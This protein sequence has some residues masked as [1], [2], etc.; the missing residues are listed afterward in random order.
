[1]LLQG[2]NRA[3]AEAIPARKRDLFRDMDAI[4]WVIVG[5]G[6]DEDQDWLEA[7]RRETWMERRAQKTPPS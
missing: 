7:I 4:E 5:H 6:S 2:T 1:M 3:I